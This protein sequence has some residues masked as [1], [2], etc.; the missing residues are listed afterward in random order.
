MSADSRHQDKL[1]VIRSTIG[2]GLDE[3]WELWYIHAR[4][5]G[6]SVVVNMSACQAEDR[7]FESRRS[8]CSDLSGMEQRGKTLQ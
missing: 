3:W 2:E 6:R 4:N 5:R 1:P 7:G 8:R